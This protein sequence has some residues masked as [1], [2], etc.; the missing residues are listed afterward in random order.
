MEYEPIYFRQHVDD[1]FVPFKSF[2]HLKRFQSYLNSCHINTSFTR[3]TKENNKILFFDV[4][5]I[6]KRDKFTTYVSWKPPSSG[7]YTHFNVFF[8]STCKTSMIYTLLNRYFRVCS[9][10]SMFHSKLTLLKQMFQKNGYPEKF[11][12][13]CFKLFL[14]RIQILNGKVP[15]VKK[16]PLQLLLPYLET[17][18]RQTRTTWQMSIK[19]V[20]NSIIFESQNKPCNN[21]SRPYYPYSYIRCELQVSVW[22]MHRI[23]SQRTC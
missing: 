22:I 16:N 12:D 4:K 11:V 19:G 9:N 23:V 20:L 15:T 18:S 2:G 21:A 14:N 17:I 1:I 10:W 8:S 13:K 6:R 7:V 5:V 3:K